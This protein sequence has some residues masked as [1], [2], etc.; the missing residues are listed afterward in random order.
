[1]N[2]ISQNGTDLS[3]IF[4]PNIITTDASFSSLISFTSGISSS[5]VIAS[6]NV[7]FTSNYPNIIFIDSASN[8][9][10][11]LPTNPSTSG[12]MIYVRQISGATART[13]TYP[14][15][16]RLA[17]SPT[18]QAAYMS[19]SICSLPAGLNYWYLFYK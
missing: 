4:A 2:Y 19:Y 12:I 16:I 7:T 17:N 3:T 11:N 10:I 15:Q 8:F 5:Y 9:S 18:T 1:M 13:I 6:S 14:N